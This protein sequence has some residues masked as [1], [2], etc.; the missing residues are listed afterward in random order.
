MLS[1]VQN[2]EAGKNQYE[3]HV[4]SLFKVTFIPPSGVANSAILTEQCRKAT[5]WKYPNPE[6]TTQK[7]M[8]ASRAQTSTEVDNIQEID[9]AFELN[10]NNALQN[11]VYDII[12]AW[13]NK[14]FNPA[15]GERG[16]KKDYTGKIV[17]ESF[18]ANG[19]IYWSRTLHNCFP[20]GNLDTIGQNDYDSAEPVQLEV[21]WIAEWFTEKKY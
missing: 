1:H 3:A 15:T 18:A 20:T 6:H 19:D 2:S 4:D 21:K 14:R 13:M 12:T 8:Q 16:M 17:I 7:F 10:L 9:T 5:G 11:Y